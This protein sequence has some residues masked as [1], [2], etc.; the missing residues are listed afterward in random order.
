MKKTISILLLSATLMACAEAIPIITKVLPT[1]LD[2]ATDLCL[3]TADEEK[4]KI[5]GLSPSEWC[6]IPSNLEPFIAAAQAGQAEAKG[7]AGLAE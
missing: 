5:G 1:L 3:L 4:D 2:V 6:M 7:A